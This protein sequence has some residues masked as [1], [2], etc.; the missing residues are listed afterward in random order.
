[1]KFNKLPVSDVASGLVKNGFTKAM[2]TFVQTSSLWYF[3]RHQQVTYAMLGLWG[4]VELVL[5][6]GFTLSITDGLRVISDAVYLPHNLM[7]WYAKYLTR[8]EPNFDKTLYTVVVQG[9]LRTTVDPNDLVEW[10]DKTED[11]FL[12]LAVYGNDRSTNNYGYNKSYNQDKCMNALRRDNR[13]AAQPVTVL[14]L[15]IR[16]I[17]KDARYASKVAV[18]EDNMK[19]LIA[20]HMNRISEKIVSELTTNNTNRLVQTAK[21]PKTGQVEKTKTVVRILAPPLLQRTAAQCAIED[22]KVISLQVMEDKRNGVLFAPQLNDEEE[23]HTAILKKME[24]A[25]GSA[26]PRDLQHV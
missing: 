20:A 9:E 5:C 4:H 12:M 14:F 24:Q 8:T 11:I 3:F 6:A 1:M 17:G 15:Q 7:G 13:S 21:N 2:M 23:S 26:A 18:N 19:T 16:S 10:A 25:L 22:T